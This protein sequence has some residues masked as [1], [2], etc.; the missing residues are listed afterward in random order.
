MRLNT[1]LMTVAATALISTGAAGTA[2]ATIVVYD[3]NLN[4]DP[5]TQEG[6]PGVGTITGTFSINTSNLD[7]TNINLMEK[8]NTSDTFGGA[9][10]T[11]TFTSLTFDNS[12]SLWTA[13]TGQANYKFGGDPYL[14]VSV[15]SNCCEIDG[16]NVG[17]SFQFDFAYPQGGAVLP[18]NFDSITSGTNYLY[19]NVTPALQGSVPE[20]AT[21]AMMLLGVGMIGGGL[22]M[23][24][25]KNVMA[26]TAA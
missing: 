5:S 22:R 18:G 26:P 3:V 6:G 1:L 4:F 2:S 11:P 14:F 16:I 10:G 9:F 20:P 17:P 15:Q 25:R 12:S 24:R 13:G 19:G 23:A 7:L 21:W 8:T